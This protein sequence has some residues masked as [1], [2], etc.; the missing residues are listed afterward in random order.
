MQTDL[1]KTIHNR[2]DAWVHNQTIH[3]SKSHEQV[4]SLRQKGMTLLA[5]DI[6]HWIDTLQPDELK[7][8]PPLFDRKW[9]ETF[10]NGDIVESLGKAY[11][12]YS[13]RRCPRIPNG[14]FLLI[15][16]IKQIHGAQGDFNHPTRIEA[17]YDVPN[18]AWYLMG[19]D[20]G[21][22]PLSILMEIVL[23]PCGVLSAWH[24]TPLRF[25][26]ENYFFRNLDGDLQVM[27]NTDLRGKT[28]T[29][30]SELMRTTFSG[31]IIIQH[32]SFALICNHETI[33]K[34]TSSFGYFP[35][36]TM[37]SQVGLD[38]GRPSQ[39]WG[40]EP[41]SENLASHELKQSNGF[42][43]EHH[44][45]K[46]QLIHH[47]WI[48]KQGGL[49]DQGYAMASRQNLPEDWFYK[50]HFYQDPV[51][52]GSLGI[53]AIIH[54]FKA[55]IRSKEGIETQLTLADDSSFQWK[56]RGQVLPINQKMWIEVH[57]KHLEE[58]LDKKVYT[59]EA[60]LWA[61]DMRIYHIDN[62]ALHS[63]KGN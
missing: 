14:D 1:M 42:N 48:S 44:S 27:Q 31:S 53:E 18:D 30:Q 20:K 40:Y 23:Q 6:S 34:G 55:L 51:M 62:L 13:G 24:G 63:I 33:L 47:L 25:P 46:L 57:L 37:A 38:G 45:E 15:S 10:S 32:F 12:I 56:Y 41:E 28:V 2:Y 3:L 60:S 49:F 16:R 59:G 43:F 54:A 22:L 11:E 4:L 61:D 52:P 21:Q 7:N 5:K 58:H 39:P 36:E 50:N 19:A 35:E 17:E 9:L 29:V 8:K 26:E